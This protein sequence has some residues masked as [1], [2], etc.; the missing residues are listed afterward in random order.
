MAAVIFCGNCGAQNAPGTAFCGRCGAALARPAAAP[1]AS[2]PV[3]P[4]AAGAPAPAYAGGYAAYPQDQQVPYRQAVVHQTQ[5]WI[6]GL[7]AGAVLF[8]M[9]VFAI[10]AA[11]FG[12][13]ANPVRCTTPGCQKVSNAPALGAPH[14][15][16]SKAVGYSVDYYDHPEYGVPIS[17]AQDDKSITWKINIWP[18]TL[19]GEKVSGRSAQQLV[20]SIQ[21][22]QV[23]DAQYLYTI[24]GLTIGV[25]PGY[26]NVYRVAL[27]TNGGQTVEAR[28][29]VAAAVKNGVAVELLVIGPYNKPDP[30]QDG[31][32]NP[33]NTVLAQV[34]NG[35]IKFVTW[36]GDPEP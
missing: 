22:A 31:H 6:W 30:K 14:R 7:A 3:A 15:Y 11:V 8:L 27:K 4:V 29:I 34:A 18:W 20:E 16:T 13:S 9:I 32:P 1:A 2:A 17:V 19:N 26:G 5:W 36:P 12:P 23:P 33:S 25:T 10:V 21:Q 35:Y 28:L 24:P